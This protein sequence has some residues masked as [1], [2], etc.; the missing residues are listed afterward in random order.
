MMTKIVCPKCGREVRLDGASR[1]GSCRA[2]GT[3]Y[4]LGGAASLDAAEPRSAVSGGG[5]VRVSA[6]WH[7]SG[8]YPAPP[9]AALKK[10]GDGQKVKEKKDASSDVG[11]VGAA[12]VGAAAVGAAMAGALGVAKEGARIAA[13]ERA[14]AEADARSA[15]EKRAAAEADA[16]SAAEQKA[17]AEADARSAAEQKAAAEADARSAAEQ[18]AAA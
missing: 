15:A 4:S 10:E 11:A 16:R 9:A 1:S 14:A 3:S 18:K 12:S 6:P 8:I 13:E 17:A 5:S 2:C 7:R